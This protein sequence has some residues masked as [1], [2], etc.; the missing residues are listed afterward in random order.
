MFSRAISGELLQAAK[1]YS[2]VTL[3]G[4]RQSGKTTIV[5][6]LFPLKPYINLEA[7]DIRAKIEFDPREFLKKHPDGAILDEIQRF[8]E[9]LSYIQVHVDERKEKGLFILTGSHQMELHQAISQ[10]LAGRTALF[11]L[12]PMSLEELAGA[13]KLKSLDGLLLTGGYP[14]LYEENLEPTSAYRYYFQTYVERDLWQ[15]IQVKDLMQFERFIKI[16]AG[17]IGN[18]I[19]YDSLANDVGVSAPTIKNWISILEASFILFRLPPYFE[20][21]GKRMI[22]SP[23]LY[24][25]DVGLACY[26]LGLENVE[27]VNRDPLRGALFENLVVLEALKYRLNHGKDPQLYYY[28]DTQGNEIDLLFPIGRH[29]CP[30]EIKSSSTYH[31][32]FLK[33]LAKSVPLLGERFAK[34][35]LV[36]G[37]EGHELSASFDLIS[38]LKL[39]DFLARQ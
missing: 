28:R 18:L 3:M 5:R 26:L 30:I 11:T 1:N 8:P 9:L 13:S 22:K 34:G 36:Y 21:F 37:G 32:D 7:P 19:N 27:Q 10:S 4:P 14:R 33:G 20:N 24:F 35:A 29:L 39:A 25:T 31:R 16:L 6:E 38:Y 2:V 17:R 15:L 12:L 23:K